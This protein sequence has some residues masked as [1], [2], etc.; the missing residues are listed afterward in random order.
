MGFVREPKLASTMLAVPLCVVVGVSASL[1]FISSAHAATTAAAALQRQF[2]RLSEQDARWT[3]LDACLKGSKLAVDAITKLDSYGVSTPDGDSLGTV[4]YG[5]GGHTKFGPVT[6]TFHPEFPPPPSAEPAV[7]SCIHQTFGP[8][9]DRS[10]WVKPHRTTLK[11]AAREA[12]HDSRWVRVRTCLKQYKVRFSY[13]STFPTSIIAN[14]IGVAEYG[15]LIGFT[16]VGRISFKLD[17]GKT[18]SFG[19]ALAFTAC[20]S[21]VYG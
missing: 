4:N 18:G 11:A 19:N 13:Q 20:L 14:H 12:A 3:G 5:N 8:H 6:W 9:A 2:P 7:V 10:N 17:T 1:A 16:N 15:H 21:S